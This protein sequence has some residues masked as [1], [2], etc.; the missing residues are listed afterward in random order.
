MSSSR[1]ASASAPTAAGPMATSAVS[2]ASR[3]KSPCLSST[4]S[5]SNGTASSQ[6]P[7]NLRAN[8]A[9]VSMI[10]QLSKPF[11]GAPAHRVETA[12][13]LCFH[14]LV[15][16]IHVARRRERGQYPGAVWRGQ[17]VAIALHQPVDVVRQSRL[18][19]RIGDVV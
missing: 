11:G 13:R 15:E 16:P 1:I 3:T 12:P 5:T 19:Q 10:G 4:V 9:I 7:G 8:C 2:Q 14:L 6:L 18:E 17:P